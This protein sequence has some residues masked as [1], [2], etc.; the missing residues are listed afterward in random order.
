MVKRKRGWKGA[1]KDPLSRVVVELTMLRS[2]TYTR[3]TRDVEHISWL[4]KPSSLLS[5]YKHG[6]EAERGEVTRGSV[7]SMG[8]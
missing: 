8:V 6:E 3:Q 5:S 2:P 1:R 7:D 4:A